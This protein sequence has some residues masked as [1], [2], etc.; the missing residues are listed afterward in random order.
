MVNIPKE[1]RDSSSPS[2]KRVVQTVTRRC[3]N[4]GDGTIV[5]ATRSPRAKSITEQQRATGYY[6]RCYCSFVPATRQNY[7]GTMSRCDLILPYLHQSALGDQ[8][9]QTIRSIKRRALRTTKISEVEASDSEDRSED[10]S[11]DHDDTPHRNQ[12][13]TSVCSHLQ[14]Q[15]ASTYPYTDLTATTR[16]SST[17]VRASHNRRETLYSET[18]PA[19]TRNSKSSGK[20]FYW[21]HLAWRKL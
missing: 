3:R 2:T 7:Q 18:M 1:L 19:I 21:E 14:P 9:K 11:D 15:S 12:H 6:A 13:T 16:P 20:S 8:D 17:L 5:K 10:D 4:A